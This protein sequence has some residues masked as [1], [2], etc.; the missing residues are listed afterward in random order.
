MTGCAASKG[1]RTMS[2]FED[3]LRRAMPT[4]EQAKPIA[5]AVG[6]L[7]LGR[8]L[9]P[10]SS[11]PGQT[12][13]PDATGGNVVGGLGGLISSLEAHGLGDVVKS[14][15]GSGANLPIDPNQLGAALGRET[16]SALARHSGL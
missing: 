8:L 4:A 5:I 10:G 15:V 11:V 6:G 12:V 2:F 16:I 9:G 14:W 13:A 7:I 3:A 1:D